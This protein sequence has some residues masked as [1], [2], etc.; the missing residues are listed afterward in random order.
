MAGDREHLQFPVEAEAFVGGAAVDLPQQAL[1]VAGDDVGCHARTR[2]DGGVG[3]ELHTA[4]SAR[5]QQCAGLRGD[6]D[7]RLRPGRC[8]V[9]G[10]IRVVEVVDDADP[11]PPQRHDGGIAE[12]SDH[13]PFRAT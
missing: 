8:G 5:S 7:D 3:H 1:P 9:L 6:F 13:H 2:A 4:Q 12:W 11:E 10:E